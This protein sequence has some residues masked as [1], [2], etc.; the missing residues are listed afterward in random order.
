MFASASARWFAT[1]RSAA[2]FCSAST[3]AGAATA[4]APAAVSAR[5]GWFALGRRFFGSHGCARRLSFGVQ[6]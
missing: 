4:F 6:F 1:R 5:V 3:G 2:A